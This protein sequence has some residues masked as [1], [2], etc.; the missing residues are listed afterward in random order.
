MRSNNHLTHR[1]AAQSWRSR[2][3]HVLPDQILAIC[4]SASLD[5]A[6]FAYQISI[7]RTGEGCA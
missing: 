4:G 6:T 3:G 5:I 7:T 1:R 2:L